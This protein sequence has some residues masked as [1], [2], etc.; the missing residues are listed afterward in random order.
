MRRKDREQ[1]KEFAYGVLSKCE[2]AT[3]SIVDLN[4]NP[5]CIPIT[6]ANDMQYIYFHSAKEGSKIDILKNNPKV[7]VSCVGDTEILEDKFTTLYE[8]AIVRGVAY[9]VIND[10]EKIHALKLLCERHT[11]NNMSN[12]ND[13][14]T[15]SLFRTAIFKISIVEITGKAKK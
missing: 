14:I 8:S 4:G 12:F 7:C 2:Y 1:S 15:R 11:P 3:L 10:S 13:A 5:Y 9:E 6:I